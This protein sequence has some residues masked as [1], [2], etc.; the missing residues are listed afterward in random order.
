MEK[1]YIPLLKTAKIRKKGNFKDIAACLANLGNPQKKIKTVHIAGTNGKGTVAHL[2]SKICVCAEFK[3]GLF[4]SPHITDVRER[5]IIN[6]KKLGKKYFSE[7]FNKVQKAQ[8]N[9]LT[10]FENLTVMSFLAFA[11][12]NVDIAIIETGI[13]GTKDVTNIIK[14]ILSIITSVDFDHKD[15]LGKTLAQITKEKAGIIKP[16]IPSIIG[17]SGNKAIGL[18]KNISK[19]KL[20]PITIVKNNSVFDYVKTNW[21]TFKTIMKDKNGKIW[22]LGL[23]GKHQVLNASIAFKAI[24]E[25]KKSGFKIK[26][27]DIKTA[28]A[29]VKICGR[30]EVIKHKHQNGKITHF[31]IDGCHNLN[32]MEAFVD[33]Y[34]SAPFA[35]TKSCLMFSISKDKDY[36]KI[37]KLL[38]EC[39]ENVIIC[40]SSGRRG[41][42]VKTALKWFKKFNPSINAEAI[43][44]FN[45]AFSHAT[46]YDSVAIAGSFYQAGKILKKLRE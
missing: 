13:G 41:L 11:E 26:L 16:K 7:I 44:K 34:L 29:K 22:E 18:I 5:I 8:K 24:Q 10:F 12:K 33:N 35:K 15:I 37:I 6:E 2:I 9:K 38:A 39:F 45:T 23:I 27:Q 31:I 20:S 21:K 40:N 28:F 42:E 32:A 19:R 43:Y 17:Y 25:L 36:R 30:F 4:T 46:K 3:T 14:P 1:M